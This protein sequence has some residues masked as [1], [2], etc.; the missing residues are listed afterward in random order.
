MAEDPKYTIKKIVDNITLKKD[1]ESDDAA[2]IFLYHDGPE[3]LKE[4]F[5]DY[6]VVVTFSDARASGF[7]RHHS[8]SVHHAEIYPVHVM[9]INKY[10]SGSLVCTGE[11]MQHKMKEQMRAV[12]EAAAVAATYKL[13]ITGE[14]PS[15]KRIGGLSL[16]ETTFSITYTSSVV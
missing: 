2:L 12:I 7:R 14:T 4:I 9:T 10:V 11:K 5:A 16:W 3:T 1:N 15:N 6:D 8:V 13:E